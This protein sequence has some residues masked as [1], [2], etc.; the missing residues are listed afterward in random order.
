MNTFCRMNRHVIENIYCCTSEQTAQSCLDYIE[1][2]N[3]EETSQLKIEVPFDQYEEVSHYVTKQVS[4]MDSATI[5]KQGAFTYR[6]LK[7]IAEAG[8]IH[9]LHMDT[10]G[11]IY[12]IDDSISLSAVIAFAQSK[13]NGTERC[14]AIENAV[15]T[16]LTILGEPFAQD[17]LVKKLEAATLDSAPLYRDS[18]IEQMAQLA[19]K[20][21]SAPIRRQRLFVNQEAVTGAYV[22]DALTSEEINVLVQ[23]ELSPVQLFK[24]IARTAAS[25][26]SGFVGM[27]VGVGIGSMIPNVSTTIISIIGAMM[28]LIIGSSVAPNLMKR[29]LGLFVKAE[30]LQMLKIFQAQLKKSGEEFLLSK[31][32]LKQALHDFNTLHD[33]PEQLRMMQRS[34]EKEQFAKQLV[35]NELT[36]IVKLRMYLH[37]PMNKELCETLEII[38]STKRKGAVA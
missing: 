10:Q 19:M 33:M 37:V 22:T 14:E 36:R 3:A 20:K 27:L 29:T 24:N 2:A 21:A 12:F 23:A 15:Y 31:L 35:E 26:T 5:V 34:T 13:W 30:A 11:R 4:M 9:Q 7:R 6:Q 25:V 16:G 32:E 18:D 38:N 17:V 8:N 1:L 28:G